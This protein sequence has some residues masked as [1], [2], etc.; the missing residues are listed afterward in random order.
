MSWPQT[1]HSAPKR[2][3]GPTT[4]RVDQGSAFASA[5][6][7][8]LGSLSNIPMRAVCSRPRGLKLPELVVNDAD[9]NSPQEMD[10]TA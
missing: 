8:F 10:E 4:I 9:R 5:W 2:N 7:T 1:R 3:A 6:R